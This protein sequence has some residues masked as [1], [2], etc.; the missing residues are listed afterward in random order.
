MKKV[1]YCKVKDILD[2]AKSLKGLCKEE[3][4]YLLS[5]HFDR[6]VNNLVFELAKEIKDN[7]YGK[8]VVFFTPL[9]I[10]NICQNECAYCGFQKSNKEITRKRL[11]KDELKEEIEFLVNQGV[12]RVLMVASEDPLLSIEE[13]CE[14]IELCYATKTEKGEIRRVN[15][16][17]APLKKEEFKLLKN[18]KIGTYQV[19]QET[20]NEEK[21]GLYHTA[22]PKSDFKFRYEAPFR[23]IEAGIDDIGMGVLF[24]LDDPVNE[25]RG[26]FDHIGEMERRYGIGPHTISVPR[27]KRALG[28]RL[29]YEPPYSIDDEYFAYIVALLRIAV[30]YTGIILST[31]ESKALRDRLIDIG[32]SQISAG[33]STSPGGYLTR[34]KEVSEQFSISD[35]RSLK[36]MVIALTEKGYLPS[37]CTAC[38]RRGRTGEVFMELAKTGNI[39]YFCDKNALLSFAEYIANFD[40]ENRE[41]LKVYLEDLVQC[42]D[43]DLKNKVNLIFLGHKDIYY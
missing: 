23:A 5:H 30:P 40:E 26:L 1:D 21:Y 22:G 19:F 15:V 25:I 32:V 4:T 33:S 6:E 29:S 8:R 41:Y 24:G 39:K 34:K 3:I 35:N 16:N 38:Y 31:R 12:K 27:I 36:E 28:A 14:Y 13:I 7:I 42:F 10:S 17:I 11:T 43:E 37:F 20:Y 9:Y 2:K 18:A